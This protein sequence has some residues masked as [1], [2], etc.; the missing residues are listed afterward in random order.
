M[1]TSTFSDSPQD[2]YTITAWSLTRPRRLF[3]AQALVLGLTLVGLGAMAWGYV[4]ALKPVTLQVNQQSLTILTNQTTVA[5]V[6]NDAAIPL[7]SEDIV[8]PAPSAPLPENQSIQVRLAR[9]IQIQADGDSITR[10]TQ[11]KTVGEA[12]REANIT[13][14]LHDRVL[15]DGSVVALT[16]PLPQTNDETGAAQIAVQRAVP[17]EVN[18]N[19]A[20]TTFYTTAPTLGEALRQAGLVVYLG[21]AV[22]PDLGTPVAPGW[23]VYIRRSRAATINVDGKTIRTRTLGDT[24][25][26]LIAQEGIQ[27]AGKDYTIP[28]ATE[29]VREGMNVQVMRVKE[30]FIT[31][32]EPIPFD[33]TWQPDS[34]LEIDDR[35]I[36][37]VGVDG[38][39]KRTIRINYEN[40]REVARTIDKEWIEAAPVTKIINYG[41][42]IVH[43]EVTLP[44]GSIVTYWRKIRVL[45]TSY[46][47]ASSGKAR[48]HPEFGITYLGWQAG[49]GIVAVDPKVINLRARMYVPGYGLA[50]AG[51]TGGRIKGRRVDLGYDESDLVL[52][53]KWV[54]IY[55]LDPSPPLDQIHWIIPDLPRSQF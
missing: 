6:L 41:T 22:T 25:A 44:D 18:D 40:G 38:V 26:N 29:A 43:R 2:D 48:T 30:D 9:A 1:S 15:L 36:T 46:T 39:K 10:R 21:D 49:L 13:L 19:G 8:F 32:S 24:V 35:Q 47:A 28:A 51:D 37:Q 12:L 50:T 52:W 11:S 31:E 17:I 55:L 20:L 34:A 23:Q 3:D 45:A 33:T 7:S 42:K 4:S 5:G 53:Y 54:D 16:A 27:L 14:K